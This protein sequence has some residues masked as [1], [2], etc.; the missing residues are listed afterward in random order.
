[1][2]RNARVCAMRGKCNGRYCWTGKT[3]LRGMLMSFADSRLSMLH[4]NTARHCAAIA[5]DVVDAPAVIRDRVN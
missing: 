4:G 2:N 5:A 1:M 3:L